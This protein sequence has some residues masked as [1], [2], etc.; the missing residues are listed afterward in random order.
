MNTIVF[1]VISPMCLIIFLILV[2]VQI[3]KSRINE[4][5]LYEKGLEEF[6][7]ANYDKAKKL[8]LSALAK[9]SDF[10]EALLRLG[11]LYFKMHDY[12]E[13]K[14]CFE[15]IIE[16][17][18]DNFIATYNLALTMQ[19][20]N[21]NDEA[22]IFYRKAIC[23]ND[24]DMDSYYNLGIMN[25]EEKNYLEAIGLFEKAQLLTPNK[26]AALFYSI[27]CRDELCKYDKAEEGQEIINAYLKIASKSDV[28]SDFYTA[29]AKSYAKMGNLKESTEFCKKSLQMNPEDPEI[30]KLFGLICIIN[31]DI[32]AAK[33]NLLIAT[34]LDPHNEEIF[35]IM[36]YT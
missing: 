14:N 21:L 17:T 25:Y 32:L 9:K 6:D 27:K 28:P 13:A 11:L 3:R 2:L 19:M 10:F 8:F 7:L 36:K 35:N 30:Y 18:P 29:I 24:K 1:T 34:Q 33:T 12:I 20:L 5:V 23:L 22:K 31:N 4:N 15:K 26:T 16:V